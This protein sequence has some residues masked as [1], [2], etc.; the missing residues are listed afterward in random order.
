LS[1]AL[2][3]FTGTPLPEIRWRK[4]GGALPWGRTTYDN[5]GK[6]L[7]IKHV[8][9]EDAGEYTC[10]ASNGVGLAK[11]HSVAL[12][13]LAK[14]RF[15]IE[16]Q[17]QTAAEGETVVFE[18]KADGV[19]SPEIK[20]IHNG[21]PI[22]EAPDNANRIVTPERITI[23]NLKKTDTGNYGCNATNAIGYVYKDVYVNVLGSFLIFTR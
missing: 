16:P 13:V 4:Q 23:R 1:S 8:D 18:C 21:R 17:I 12:E 2:K 14:P 3:Q 6:T 7:V 19:P 15:L 11:S 10:E 5:Y 9:F 20:W 22:H